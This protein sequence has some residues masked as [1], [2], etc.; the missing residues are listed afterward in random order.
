[1]LSAIRSPLGLARLIV[2]SLTSP[3][4]A[5]P[6]GP[7]CPLLM[8]SSKASVRPSDS[9]VIELFPYRP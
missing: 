7:S 3:K 5:P 2:R 9:Q 4:V 1:L 6:G 8:P